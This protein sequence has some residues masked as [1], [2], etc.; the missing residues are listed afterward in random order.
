RLKIDQSFVRIIGDDE[1]CPRLVED[2]I[3]MADN[4]GM[5]TIAEGIETPRQAELLRKHG[6]VEGQGYCFSRPIPADEFASFRRRYSSK[7]RES[8]N[9]K[10]LQLEFR[11]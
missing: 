1:E 11:P 5:A 3:R 4:L 7:A 10:P 9:G 2:I 8:T 6:C